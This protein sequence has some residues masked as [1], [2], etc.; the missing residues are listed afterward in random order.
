MTPQEIETMKAETA[1]A[2]EAG[3]KAVHDAL[4]RSEKGGLNMAD[5]VTKEHILSAEFTGGNPFK[6]VSWGDPGHQRP[7]WFRG[8]N[9]HLRDYFG[10]RRVHDERKPEEYASLCNGWDLGTGTRQASFDDASRVA[11]YLADVTKCPHW[12]VDRGESVSPRYAVMRAF[13]VG[14]PVSYAFNGDYYPCGR[15]VSITG[16]DN[17]IITTRDHNGRERKFWR[18]R[19]SESW[20][21]DGMWS[22]VS[23]W[24]NDQNPSF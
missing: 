7:A 8:F 18:R 21:S 24:H 10:V 11:A 3:A 22:L 4:D 12:P 5:A 6:M 20:K 16:K 17:R 2:Y 23:G 1:A 15:I 14:E 13:Q 9:D 19:K